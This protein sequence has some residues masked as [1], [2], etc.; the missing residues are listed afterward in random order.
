M[1]E[2]YWAALA[3]LGGDVPGTVEHAK[4]ARELS[5]PDDPL[6]RT[7]AAGPS[8]L[9]FWSSGDLDAGHSAYAECM[10]GLY[11]GGYIADTYGCAV[12]LAD[13]RL[14]QGRLGEALRTYDQALQRGSE[15]GGPVLRGT[16]D[17]YVGMS[18]V[19]C[20]RG[21]LPA[22]AAHLLRSQELGE[23][24]GLPQSP[25]RC[26]SRWPGYARLE[27]T[28]P[29]HSTCSTRRNGSTTAISSPMCG[30]FPPSG[31][32]CGSCRERW[33]TRFAGPRS[34]A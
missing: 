32:G 29:V 17:M 33:I 9:A 21:D 2:L 6:C 8:G 20:E 24:T 22:A 34:V 10:A 4:C 18:E 25:Y 28:W 14:T 13:I 31:H 7:A 5:A 30:R 19:A 1:I 3:L 23:D 12:A 27:E 26:G 11:R 15:Q 16:A